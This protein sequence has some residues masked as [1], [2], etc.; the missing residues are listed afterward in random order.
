MEAL[1]QRLKECHLSLHPQKT[2]IVYCKDS[3]RKGTYPEISFDFLG[4]SFRPRRAMSKHGDVFSGYTPALS[5]KA[6][7]RISTAIRKWKFQKWSGHSIEDIARVLNPVVAGWIGY[8][9]H[10]GRRELS[11]MYNLLEFALIRWAWKKYKKLR[12][13][14]RKSKAYIGLLHEQS[15]EM[16]TG[17]CIVL[18]EQ[19][20]ER[21]TYSS[22]RA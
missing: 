16:R 6:L 17:S 20:A 2:K 5:R 7:K 14:Y 18:A 10:F 3:N 1:E 8:Y 21:F 11:R 9:G 4:F 13:S 19:E 15:P 12:R 22:V